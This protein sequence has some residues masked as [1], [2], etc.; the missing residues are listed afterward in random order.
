MDDATETSAETGPATGASRG[1]ESVDALAATATATTWHAGGTAGHERAVLAFFDLDGTLV[2]GQ[3]QYLLIGFLRRRGV[4]GAGFM[5]GTV[6]WFLGYKL[7]LFRVTEKAR[8]RGALPFRGMTEGE[9][10]TLMEEFASDVMTPRLNPRAVAALAGHRRQG[11]RVIVLSA[12]LHPLVRAL[13]QTLDVHE[14]VAAHC[15]IVDGRYSG[16]LDSSTPHG[17]EKARIAREMMARAGADPA[18]C[19]AYA[20]HESDLQLLESVGHPVAVRPKPG[21]LRTAREGGWPVLD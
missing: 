3:T 11:D 5:A 4:V 9:V 7:G 10:S 16:T 1:S 15:Q 21:L 19:W 6:A 12:A 17:P 2:I 18:G 14:W 8:A 20:D 13:C